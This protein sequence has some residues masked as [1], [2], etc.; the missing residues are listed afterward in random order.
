[1]DRDLTPVAVEAAA[2]KANAGK[3]L[4][5]VVPPKAMRE[6]ECQRSATQMDCLYRVG[7]GPL[8]DVKLSM[9]FYGDAQGLV[10]HVKVSKENYWVWEGNN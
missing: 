1:M 5:E 7:S 6:R 4:E 9:V 10:R 8:R 2:M 3:K